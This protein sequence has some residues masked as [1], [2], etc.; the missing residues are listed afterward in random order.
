MISAL[1]KS[2]QLYLITLDRVSDYFDLLRVELKIHEHNIALR[3]AGFAVAGLFSLLAIV[4]LGLAIIVSFWDSP[5]RA[6][7]A[8]FVVLLY[9]GIAGVCLNLA[10]KHFRSQPIANTLRTEFRRDLD[11]IKESV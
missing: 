9:G 4:F 3:I 8:W 5:F 11:V 1:H 6:L 7:A 10:L 2:R